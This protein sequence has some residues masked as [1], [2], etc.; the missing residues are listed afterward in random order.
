M[1]MIG[2]LHLHLVNTIGE[3]E[4]WR[5]LHD[6]YCSSV[7]DDL[8]CRATKPKRAPIIKLNLLSFGPESQKRAEF[9]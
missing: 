5:M 9:L 8:R 7:G 4:S 2:K 1:T 3:K 6:R